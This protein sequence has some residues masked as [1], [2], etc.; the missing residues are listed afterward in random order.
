MRMKIMST[1][2]VTLNSVE[3]LLLVGSRKES[4]A[5]SPLD[6]VDRDGGLDERRLAGGGGELPR[7]N[8]EIPGGHHYL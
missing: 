1:Y 7:E 5:V 2:Q 4:G 6:T 8:G 3:C